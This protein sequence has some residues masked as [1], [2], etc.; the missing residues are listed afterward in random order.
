V[1]VKVNHRNVHDFR[2]QFYKLNVPATSALLR[3]RL[4]ADFIKRHGTRVLTK[5]L[6]LK[7][8]A[9]YVEADTTLRVKMPAEG[10]YLI[11]ASHG[12][13]VQDR[14]SLVYVSK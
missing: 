8:T 1:A 9:D 13:G 10:V 7:R 6:V 14:S 12:S 2:L 5:D 4:D 3:E 11:T